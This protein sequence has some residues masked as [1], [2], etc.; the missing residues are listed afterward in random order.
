MILDRKILSMAEAEEYIDKEN[1]TDVKG[2]IKKFI[3][4]KPEKAKEL[5][6]KL[7]ELDLMK[8][9]NEHISKLI[10]LLPENKEDLNKIVNDV[11]L[12]EDETKKI[13]DTIK[14][15]K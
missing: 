4:I 9:K 15:F 13:L 2:F 11:G 6:K 3:K 10:D 12:D 5:R 1:E 14:E 8:L 7:K